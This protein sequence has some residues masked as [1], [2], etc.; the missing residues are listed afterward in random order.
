MLG[1]LKKNKKAKRLDHTDVSKDINSGEKSSF[2]VLSLLLKASKRP[3]GRT[4]N[5][6]H[7]AGAS[8]S[9]RLTFDTLLNERNGSS[10]I[11]LCGRLSDFPFCQSRAAKSAKEGVVSDL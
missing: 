5:G 9:C 7:H 2:T 3:V 10:V 8:V 6:R 4:G 11:T 1:Y